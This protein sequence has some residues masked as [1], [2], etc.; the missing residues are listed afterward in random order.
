M[1]MGIPNAQG[2]HHRGHTCPPPLSMPLLLPSAGN[3]LRRLCPA[4]ANRPSLPRSLP[5]LTFKSAMGHL[6]AYH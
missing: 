6:P 1:V 5:G 3:T 4:K 2:W